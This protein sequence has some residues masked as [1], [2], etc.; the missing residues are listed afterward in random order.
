MIK[1]PYVEQGDAGGVPVVMLH[2]V[3][4]SWRSFEPVLPHLPDDI[5]AIAVTQ[6]GHGDAPKPEGGYLIEDLAG[7]V[8]ELM[9]E[10]EIERAIVVGHSMGTWVA[11]QIAIDNPDRVDG[12]VL[13]GAFHGSV[14]RDP[15]VAAAMRELAD[16]PDPV[17]DEIAR[18]FQLSTLARPIAPELLDTFVRESLKV[19]AQIWRDLFLGFAELDQGDGAAQ[20]Q[21]PALLVWGD[22][23][24]FIPRE[25]QDGLLQTLPDARLGV[26][27]GV[28][29]AVHWERPK[30]FAADVAAFSRCSAGLQL[31]R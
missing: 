21:V 22:R 5:R 1:L 3:T 15:G 12:L 25:V 10:L 6:R 29:H 4:D 14:A 18:E 24:A 7:D 8:A 23:D 19:P 2:G 13:A 9:D 26:Y 20:L 11:R 27:E 17:T 30:R 31:S 28:G 16:V